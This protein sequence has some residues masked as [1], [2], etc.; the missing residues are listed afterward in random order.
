MNHIRTRKDRGCGD[1]GVSTLVEYVAVSGIL[2]A[3]FIT[4]LLLVN[5]YFMQDPVNTLTYSAFTDI[6]NGVSTRIVDVYAIAPESGNITSNYDLPDDIA[7]QSYFVEVKTD[8][9]G[10]SVQ[11]S[12]NSIVSEVALAGI[13]ASKH[14]AS[15]G[16]TT[17]AG[18]NRI[19]YD[20]SG[21]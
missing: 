8:A 4:M 18:V 12:R 5:T 6:G 7:G 16:N 9:S 3:L 19:S 17:G 1:D 21:F 14:G 13:G 20:S 10:Q 11:I 2:M 15:V